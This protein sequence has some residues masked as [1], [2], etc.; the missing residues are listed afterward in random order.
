MC[1]FFYFNTENTANVVAV[2]LFSIVQLNFSLF[3]LSPGGCVCVCVLDNPLQLSK[4]IPHKTMRTMLKALEF[5]F[6]CRIEYVFFYH[7][8]RF[9]CH[10]IGGIGGIGDNFNCNCK[11]HS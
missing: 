4:H 5:E 10:G 2:L 7:H 3:E 9:I 6:H 1:V 11:L 8:I